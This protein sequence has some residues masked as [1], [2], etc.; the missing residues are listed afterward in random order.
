[1]NHQEPEVLIGIPTL[2]GPERLRR[3]LQSIQINTPRSEPFKVVVVDDCSTP[4]NLKKN[5][6]VV[7]AFGVDMLMHQQRYG[8]ARGWN[9]L[10]RHTQA[11]YV[12]LMND[13]VEVVPDWYEALVFSLKQNP[14]AGMIGLTAYQGV[15]SSNFT[16][17]PV[18]SYNEA[19]MLRGEGMFSTSGFI[20]GFQH[21]KF[22]QIGGFDDGFFLFYEEVD[23][24]AR[25]EAAGYASYMLSYPVVIHQG[26]AST[27]DSRNLPDP[28]GV[29]AQSRER[30]KAKHGS[31][32]RVREETR[33]R[34]P[35]RSICTEWN[36]ALKVLVD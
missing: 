14:H 4:E 18:K 22:D 21:M 3:C 19:K 28:Q 15:N 32:S 36:T 13:D 26:G 25:M 5:K 2:N 35:A 33:S 30:F 8:V 29:M 17:P 31:V 1:M 7:R 24:G 6:E 16:P 20:F 27:S 9:D 11:P 12:I 10:T 23:F 34:P